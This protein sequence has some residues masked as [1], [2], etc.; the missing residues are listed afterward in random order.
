MQKPIKIIIA[1]ALLVLL[2]AACACA[3]KAPADVVTP[4]PA[5]DAPTPYLNNTV[6]PLT[7]AP[8]QTP[9][10]RDEGPLFTGFQEARSFYLQ[11]AAQMS[12][13]IDAKIGVLMRLDGE[14]PRL[15]AYAYRS[16]LIMGDD[17][18]LLMG[19]GALTDM[20]D[21]E[22]VIA[23]YEDF[24]Y[25]NVEFFEEASGAYRLRYADI[26]ENGSEILYE[27]VFEFANDRLRFTRTVNGRMEGYYEC[28]PLGEGRFAMQSLTERAIVKLI[29]PRDPAGGIASLI[30]SE[31]RS[32]RKAESGYSSIG[33]FM[34]WSVSYDPEADSIF[35]ADKLSDEWVTALEAGG[36]LARVHIIDENGGFEFRGA[37]ASGPLDEPAFEPFEPWILGAD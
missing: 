37:L 25:E 27:T 14:D 33:A 26:A 34:P 22:A 19:A 31:T 28:I 11:L 24:G 32:A 20:T 36:G 21:E 9:E 13:A 6:P 7:E 2:T 1:A 4:A 10:A 16:P 12:D 15:G 35:C 18:N 23:H 17:V 30:Y 29:S 5:T 8:E 3:G